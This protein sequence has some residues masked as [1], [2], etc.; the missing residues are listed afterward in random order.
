MFIIL[1]GPGAFESQA[2]RAL[3]E[4]GLSA[5]EV[6]VSHGLPDKTD[7][8][9]DPTVGFISLEGDDIDAA[10]A[11]VSSLGWGLRAHYHAP[12]LTAPLM[13]EVDAAH[14]DLIREIV[15]E[16]LAGRVGD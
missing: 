6:T 10:N 16:I 15:E 5:H 12:T 3:D 9:S 2:R 14:R 1:S 13:A 4:A 7:G 11:A 8:S